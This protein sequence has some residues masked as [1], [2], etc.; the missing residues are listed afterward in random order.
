MRALDLAGQKYNKLTCICPTG[1]RKESSVVWKCQCDCGNICYKPAD[2]ILDGRTTSC[3]CNRRSKSK[4]G[5]GFWKVF[6]SYIDRCK[7][8]DIEFGLT[9]DEFYNLTQQKCFYCSTTPKQV[10]A[11][12]TDFIYNG[13]DRTDNLRGYTIDNCVTCCRRCNAAKS[14][15]T[16][17]EFREWIRSVYTNFVEFIGICGT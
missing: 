5:V 15:M 3:G 11:K 17:G 4:Y 9:E 16:L 1:D 7:K 12:Y 8:R 2:V 10:S 13:I 14:D 6:S